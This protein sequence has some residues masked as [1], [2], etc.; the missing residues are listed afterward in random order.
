MSLRQ[1]LYDIE[2]ALA[3]DAESPETQQR[4]RH[5]EAQRRYR[6]RGELEVQ[7]LQETIAALAAQREQLL[8]QRSTSSSLPWKDVARALQDATYDAEGNQIKLRFQLRAKR[9]LARALY[10]WIMALASPSKL[11]PPHA[12][13]SWQLSSL[14]TTGSA[15]YVGGAWIMRHLYVQL[16][17]WIAESRFPQ[18][19]DAAE[20]V[21]SRPYV[22][23]Q[24]E[25]HGSS[26]RIVVR[27]QRV[28]SY[29]A[30]TILA[31]YETLQPPRGGQVLEVIDKTTRYIKYPVYDED[32][33]EHHLVTYLDEPDR[34]VL[35]IQGIVD[36]NAFPLRQQTRFWTSWTV[37]YRIGPNLTLLQ[38]G[39]D[40]SGLRRGG[41]WMP[42]EEFSE[43][44]AQLK[45]AGV[46]D[47][48]MMES[49]QRQ[50]QILFETANIGDMDRVDGLAASFQT[51]AE[52]SPCIREEDSSST[53]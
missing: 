36:D 42:R 52:L 4:R 3:P 18:I 35:L 50:L 34:F 1:T 14:T 20:A 41:E 17:R 13:P 2:E 22:C 7:E 26:S 24:V 12:L 39:Y 5:R 48:Q 44:Y 21:K 19:I 6:Q 51:N 28:A 29:S 40:F 9:A 43:T 10:N 31:A 45:A 49:Y 46:P 27:K 16:P 25:E 37:G 33:V 15:R 11:L 8:L 53:K 30:D 47:M 32:F 23:V 38:D